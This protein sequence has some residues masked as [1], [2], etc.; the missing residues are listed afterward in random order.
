[1]RNARLA[2]LYAEIKIARKNI[3][4]LPFNGKKRRGTKEPLEGGGKWKSQ[5]KTQNLKKKNPKT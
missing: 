4:N 2:E 3:N 5:L 1:M